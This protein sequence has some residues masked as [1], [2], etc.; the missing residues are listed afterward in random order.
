MTTT[1]DQT[2]P[3]G[4]FRAERGGAPASSPSNGPFGGW[5]WRSRYAAGLVLVVTDRTLVPRDRT[6]LDVVAGALE[7]GAHGVV[8][9][10]R[11]LPSAERRA[12]VTR[13]GELCARHGAL[14][15][16]ASM[17]TGGVTPTAT[18]A[19]TLTAGS[20]LRRDEP[21][22]TL[23]NRPRT[24]VGRSCHDLVE[25]LRA[26]DDGLDYL[27]ISPVTTT[28]SKPGYGPPLGVVGLRDLLTTARTLRTELPAV[29][30]LGGVTADNAGYWV[31]AGADGV[32]VMGAVMRA[33]DPARTV[34]AITQAVAAARELVR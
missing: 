10:E 22:Q 25:V 14:L 21:V 3:N 26:A 5:R 9:R 6:L 12:L 34:R 8:V 19:A 7:G 13:V 31:E 27:T 11:D 20:H 23:P 18:S 16:T 15:V 29:L 17:D 1:P 24:L 33:D 28:A 4:P 32:A 30:A 2:P